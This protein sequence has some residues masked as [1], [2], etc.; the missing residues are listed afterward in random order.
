MSPDKSTAQRSQAT[1]KL[2]I[3]M[4]KI[5]QLLSSAKSAVTSLSQPGGTNLKPA[6]AMAGRGQE[7]GKREAATG[8]GGKGA[9]SVATTAGGLLEVDPSF[10]SKSADLANIVRHG[11]DSASRTAKLHNKEHHTNEEGQPPSA[12]FVDDPD[13]PPLI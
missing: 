12:D 5:K 13:V 8:E 4:P 10:K 11:A 9:T 2:L 7:S 6:S 3:T 1:G